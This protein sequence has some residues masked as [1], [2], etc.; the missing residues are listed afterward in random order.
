MEV[1]DVAAWGAIDDESERPKYTGVSLAAEILGNTLRF[2][3]L[4]ASAADEIMEN[5]TPTVTLMRDPIDV[6]MEQR[7]ARETENRAQ[8]NNFES[9]AGALRGAEMN[10]TQPAGPG[11]DV[12]ELLPAKL[13]RRYEVRF[14]PSTGAKSLPLRQVRAEHVGKLVSVKGVVTRVTEVKPRVA[15][16]G[17][18][19]DTCGAEVYQEIKSRSFLPLSDCPNQ[20]HRTDATS[21]SLTLNVQS[22]KFMKYQEIKLQEPPEHVSISKDPAHQDALP[23]PSMLLHE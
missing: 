4:F 22:T 3:D 5:M 18:T 9:G 20:I 11:A 14:L 7:R 6:L 2:V 17:Y 21:A 1:D 10:P 15:V 23:P 8:A 16:A 13:V 12:H 19:C